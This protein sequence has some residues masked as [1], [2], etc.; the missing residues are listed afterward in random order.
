M[1]I[2]EKMAGKLD[3]RI[4]LVT[5]G[6]SGIKPITDDGPYDNERGRQWF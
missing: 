6:T 4:A 3:G 2:D 5:G 1:T